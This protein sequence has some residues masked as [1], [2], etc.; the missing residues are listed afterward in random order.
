MTEETRIS[1]WFEVWEKAWVVVASIYGRSEEEMVEYLAY[2]SQGFYWAI[3]GL[4]H[5][6]DNQFNTSVGT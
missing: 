5:L 1:P 3:L 6:L 2:G 4:R